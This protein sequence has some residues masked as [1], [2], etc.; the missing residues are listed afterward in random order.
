MVVILGIG[1]LGIVWVV[2]RGN[3]VTLQVDGAPIANADTVVAE[4]QAAFRQLVDDDRAHPADGSGCWF[5]PPAA[6]SGSA[7]RRPRLACGPVRLGVS[8][9]DKVW[10]T[11]TA[12]YTPVLATQAREVTGR[13]TGLRAVEA[14]DAG[15]LV[16]PDGAEPPGTQDLAAPDPLLR[17]REGQRLIGDR[18]VL[19]N[20]ER[21]LRPAA[22]RARATIDDDAAC[23]Y[24]LTPDAG[25]RRTSDGA[26]WCGPVL[27]ATSSADEPWARVPLSLQ[28]GDDF[29]AAQLRATPPT[30]LTGTQKLPPGTQL[31]RPDGRRAPERIDL[32]GPDARAQAP[33][34]VGVVADIPADLVLTPPAGDA[35]LNVP[36]RRLAVDGL[37]RVPKVG[38]G[39]AALVAASG[40][41]LVVARFRRTD[42][43]IAAG[44]SPIA[45]ARGAA[46]IVVGAR[47]TP[48]TDWSSLPERGLVVASVPPGG[49][50]VLEVVFD[51]VT[52]S[53]SLTTGQRGP[54]SRVALYRGSTEVVVGRPVNLP[55]PLP[56]GPP[57]TVFG[58]L[59]AVQVEAWHDRVGWAPPGRAHLSVVLENWQ[60]DEPCCA[61]AKVDVVTAWTL[62]LPD[63]SV[64]PARPLPPGAPDTAVVFD[65][66]DTV[67]AAEVRLSVNVT[68]EQAGL[69]ATA[70]AG[71]VAVPVA[72]PS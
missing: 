15:D 16:R 3:P 29:T 70:A 61:L 25:G 2:N 18:S 48:V 11:G 65:V 1:A 12:T 17:N 71:P 60:V 69:A 10:V 38:S 8:T 23:W 27:L 40:E 24:G 53:L 50:A 22:E 62:A 46:Q 47:R 14:L 20:V 4:A 58:V 56:A 51:G 21:T 72:L 39:R 49:D 6:G 64:V 31:Y 7:D 59:N 67:T 36:T 41:E 30:S 52:Q 13:F 63:G 19:D 33:G 28:Q 57:A 54:D 34:F 35:R 37:A 66:P 44:A 43:P 5:A 55:V 68:Y 32:A 9:G 26:L 42:P 45:S